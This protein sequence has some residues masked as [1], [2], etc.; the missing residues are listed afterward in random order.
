MRDTSLLAILT[1][2]VLA[3]GCSLLY[4]T[5]GFLGRDAG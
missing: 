5:E 1:A 2:S 4:G 3:S